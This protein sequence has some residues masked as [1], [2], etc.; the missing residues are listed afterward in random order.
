MIQSLVL[1]E[2]VFA[3]SKLPPD[4]E[5]PSWVDGEIL[6][7]IIRTKNELSI[8]CDESY[9]PKVVLS[10]R[11]WKALEVVG[12][13]EFS[14]VGLMADITTSLSEV[15]VS[16][17]VLSTYDTDY[18]LLKQDQLDKAIHALKQAGYSIREE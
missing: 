10:E 15:G 18:I 1:L 6:T 14:I 9:V 13:L 11:G 7:A 8:V 17:F 4:S 16:V 5:I 12:P 3:V 2:N